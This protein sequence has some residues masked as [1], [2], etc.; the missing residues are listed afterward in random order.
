MNYSKQL[1]TVANTLATALNI[2]FSMIEAKNGKG[3]KKAAPKKAPAKKKP[4]A[5]K[6]APTK[7]KKKVKK[8]KK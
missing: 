2:V 6:A 1:D 4:V 8:T 3:K 7:G 5:K